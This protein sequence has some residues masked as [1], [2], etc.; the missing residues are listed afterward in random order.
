MLPASTPTS[1][2]IDVKKLSYSSNDC[3]ATGAADINLRVSGDAT[4]RLA[5]ELLTYLHAHVS[6]QCK[7][8]KTKTTSARIQ[9]YLQRKA[10]RQSSW[11]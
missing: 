9:I 10:T 8:P 3:I 4:K 11:F 1:K 5:Q 6:S 7:G 2:H